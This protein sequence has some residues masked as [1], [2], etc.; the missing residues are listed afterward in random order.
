MPKMP[1]AERDEDLG[2]V[3]PAKPP[4]SIPDMPWDLGDISDDI[5]MQLY[6]QFTQWANYLSVQ[7]TLA[8]VQEEELEQMLKTT[9]ALFMARQSDEGA[10]LNDARALR[11]AD[12][13]IVLARMGLNTQRHVRKLTATLLSNCERSAAACSRELTRRTTIGIH[14]RRSST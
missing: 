4:R 9:E 2:Y 6:S 10:K 12:P 7:A 14:E 8:D 1:D 13:D 11:D 3:L 5:L